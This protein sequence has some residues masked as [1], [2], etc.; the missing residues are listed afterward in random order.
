MNDHSRP[1]PPETEAMEL[2][3]L[4]RLADSLQAPIEDSSWYAMLT[5]LKAV[6]AMHCMSKDPYP[7]YSDQA[8]AMKKVRKAIA[9]AERK[10]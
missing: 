10:L 7:I 3:R 1:D 5:A 6:S 9:K 8:G 4:R 2:D